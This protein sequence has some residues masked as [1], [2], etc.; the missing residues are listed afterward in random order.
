MERPT[1]I[2]IL[3]AYGGGNFGNDASFEAALQWARAAFPGGEFLAACENPALARERLDINGVRLR[4]W[5]KS[6]PRWLDTLLLRQPSLWLNWRECLGALRGCDLVVVAGTGVIHD[7]RDRPWGWP[8]RFVRWAL[9][10]RLSGAKLILLCVGAG[11]VINPVSRL[12][13]KWVALLASGRCYR[14]EASRN[15]MSSLGLDESA[16]PVAADLAFLLP[17]PTPTAPRRDAGNV[18]VGLCL[19][20]YRG[21]R[22]NERVYRAYIESMTHLVAWLRSCG[23]AVHMLIGQTPTDLVAVTDLEHRLG[24]RLM[25]DE[26]RRV[27]SFQETMRVVAQTDVVVAPRLHVQIAALKLRRPV[28]SISYGPM[29]DALMEAVGLSAFAQDIERID[30]QQLVGMCGELISKRTCLASMVDERVSR[31]EAA[32]PSQ[33]HAFIAPFQPP[34]RADR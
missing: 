17:T 9:A 2:L 1:R 4:V 22:K 12:L 31:L 18:A 15:Y 33:L 13:M 10:T 30:R 26:E 25:S 27:A 8:V 24:C 3:G 23:H 28:L 7:Y 20:N 14:D 29:N 21:W 19:M 34:P 32:L 6:V 16:S 5:P 11:P